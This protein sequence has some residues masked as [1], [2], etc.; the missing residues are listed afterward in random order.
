MPGCD[1]EVV[2][3]RLRNGEILD[4]ELSQYQTWEHCP[5][6][7]RDI[8]AYRIVNQQPTSASPPTSWLSATNAGRL[9]A[10]KL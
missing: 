1:G 9:P 5:P 2:D 4:D 3:V 6:K 10:R 8:I 7:D